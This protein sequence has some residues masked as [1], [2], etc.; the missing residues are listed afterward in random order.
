MRLAEERE[1]AF[2]DDRDSVAEIERREREAGHVDAASPPS[3]SSPES[4]R[5]FVRRRVKAFN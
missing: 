2:Y 4:R 5:P 1:S 3:L